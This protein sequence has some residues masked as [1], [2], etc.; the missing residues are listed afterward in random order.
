MPD[1]RVVRVVLTVHPEERERVTDADSMTR[2]RVL[3]QTTDHDSPVSDVVPVLHLRKTLKK[4][5]NYCQGRGGYS[6]CL[7]EGRNGD[8]GG[9]P[10]I[11]RVAAT[12]RRHFP[13]FLKFR[14]K[15]L[16]TLV[17]SHPYRIAG[18][19]RIVQESYCTPFDVGVQP[20]FL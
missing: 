10:R 19:K 13:L 9:H 15:Q 1:E 17:Y 20:E 11:A 5:P 7:Q 18:F 3:A 6:D 4:P 16:A 2:R 12:R 8:I 14:S